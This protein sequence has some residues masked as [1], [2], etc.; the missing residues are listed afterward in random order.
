MIIN[1]FDGIVRNNPFQWQLFLFSN[2]Q[3]SSWDWFP[4][5][6]LSFS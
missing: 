4:A 5:Y 6:N 2:R 3:S 1:T